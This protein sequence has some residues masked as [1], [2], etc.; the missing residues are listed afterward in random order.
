MSTTPWN[1]ELE[2]TGLIALVRQRT[3]QLL[4]AL[5]VDTTGFDPLGDRANPHDPVVKIS[6][7]NPTVPSTVQAATPTPF[8]GRAIVWPLQNVTLELD[9]TISNGPSILEGVR[10]HGSVIPVKNGTH[11]DVTWVYQMA[12]G[13]SGSNRVKAACID[14]SADPTGTG[15]TARLQLSKGDLETLDFGMTL[16]KTVVAFEKPAEQVNY[17]QVFAVSCLVKMTITSP[18]VRLLGTPFYGGATVGYDLAPLNSTTPVKVSLSNEPLIGENTPIKDGMVVDADFL[19]YYN[20]VDK[21]ANP[22]RH[23]V[24]ARSA[25]PFDEFLRQFRDNL[26]PGE[27]AVP[28]GPP[29]LVPAIRRDKDCHKIMFDLE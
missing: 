24:P 25:L 20:L 4:T 27:S 23:Y 16:L 5:V 2:I 6:N 11:K 9:G 29:H 18:T 28:S 3:K 13:D 15:I 22:T 14:L 21:I 19:M 17:T 10:P 1:L 12:I 8:D 26:T 7:Y